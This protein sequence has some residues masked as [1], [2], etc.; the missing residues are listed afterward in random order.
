MPKQIVEDSLWRQRF[1]SAN[2]YYREWESLFACDVLERYYESRQWNNITY[3]TEMRY[4][5][6]T[7]NKIYETI[8][9]KLDQFIP[10]NPK[11]NISVRPGNQ[12]Y[13]QDLAAQSANLK[14]DVLNTVVMD[15]FEHFQEEVQLA[16]KDSF[17]RF[18]VFEVGYAA[19]WVINPNA[20]KPLLGKDTKK[21]SGKRSK[22]IQEPRELPV[23]ERIYF[24]HIGAKRF[25]VGGV[26]HKYL[27]RCSWHG[28]YEWVHKDDLLSLNVM[29]K[30]L[31]QSASYESID[32]TVL[33]KDDH[34]LKDG[35]VKV[36]HIWDQ[37]SAMRLLVL[38]SPCVTLFQRKFKR[39]QIF[40]F[41]PD[42]RLI[43][44]GFYPI[45]PVFHWISPQDE[46]NETREMLRAHRRRFVRKF[47]VM[48]GAIDDEEIEK[49]ETG[50]DGGLIKIKRDGA[51]KPI[52]N[53]SLGAENA[54]SMMTSADDLNRITATSTEMRGVA[55]R[56]T[57][58]Q[59][60]IIN[61]RSG[62]REDAEVQRVGRW[63]SRIGRETLLQIRDKFAL[64]VWAN[65]TSDPGEK[66][67]G[68]VN[69]QKDVYTWVTAEDLNDGYDFRINVDV[70]SLS[71]VSA[72]EEKQKF[73]EFLSLVTQFPAIAFS[74][75]LIREA[76]YR[77][78]YRNEAI[79]KEMQQMA[80]MQ[81]LA[82]QQQMQQQGGAPGQAPNPGNA[83]QNTVQSQTPPQIE[84]IR[85][86]IQNQIGQRPN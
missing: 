74:P 76:A 51:I 65:L 82:R 66:L 12:D 4:R 38:D 31:V 86:Q 57:A 5:P 44:E 70:T 45:P 15:D 35:A 72:Q 46:I 30:D 34:K 39:D 23:N 50:P 26:D 78:G 41:R 27:N 85:Q 49:F 54:Q 64:G 80:L 20:P 18:G 40:D 2:R 63:L 69:D 33:D 53:A 48:E 61:Q 75:K 17:F 11:F 55:D 9:I 14:E 36:W 60:N 29:N 6:Y 56:T 43:T 28:Y 32:S 77:V 67:F 8:Q 7:I 68:T 79:I 22:V 52:D 42:R 73:I 58:T 1:D 19:D 25:R 47:Q 10:T 21:D 24:K 84:Q 81:E 71:S 37:R 83:A 62:A 16:Y 59:A 3:G 13:S